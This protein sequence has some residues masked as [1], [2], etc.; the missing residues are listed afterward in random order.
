MFRPL[1]D[2][3]PIRAAASL[4][5]C[6]FVLSITV[7][8]VPAATPNEPLNFVILLADDLG[9][10]DLTSY[11]SDLHATPNID[12]L[13]AESVKFTDAY[14]AAPVCSPTR[15]SI[16]TGKYPARL[17]MT[18]WRESSNNPPLK[19]PVIPPITVGDLPHSQTTIA[20]VLHRAGYLTAHVGKWHLGGASHYPQ[21][22][23]FDANIGGS[24]WG[25]PATFFHPYSGD[26]RYGH[27]FRYVP[28][29]EFGKEGDYLTDQLTDAA[30]DVLDHAGERPFFLNMCWYTVHT[31][32]EARQEAVDR[33]TA[34][35]KPGMNHVNPTYA[36]MVES[37]DQNVGR[38]L[39]KLEDLGVADRTVVI[40]SSDNGGFVNK[41]NGQTV[42][43]NHPLR[44]GKG[45]LYEGG[46][47]VPLLI[48]WP[49]VAP[50]GAV[51]R[52]PV[53]TIDF[54]PTILEMAGLPGDAEHN[55]TVDGKSLAPLLKDPR[56]TLDRKVMCWHYPHYYPT[57]SP[58]SSIRHGNW[59]LLE[60]HEDQ[61]LELYDLE[62][63]LSEEHNLAEKQPSKATELR[64]KLHAWRE[65]VDAQM[66]E[67]NVNRRRSTARPKTAPVSGLITLN[68]EPVAG[69][70]VV[71][72]PRKKNGSAAAGTTDA[73]GMFKMTT[74]QAGDGVIPGGYSVAISKIVTIDEDAKTRQERHLLPPKYAEPSTS[75]L[76]V[77]VAAE[78]RNMFDIELAP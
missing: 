43:N 31:P 54:Y 41:F 12:R 71:F 20:E 74:F 26:Q 39:A 45:S 2:L 63:D 1:S 30:I 10:T 35:L 55:A 51:C 61:H 15:A 3:G 76:T 42:T 59:K 66:P 38:I 37:L 60:Y 9:W 28:H 16:L 50:K 62:N 40:F 75:G 27:E 65:S 46:V 70:S 69:A 24:L 78:G 77:E 73:A 33:Y 58:V 25:A 64:D 36:A 18:I 72:A 11:G 57:T 19:R 44:S 13:A 7:S 22:H 49:G 68:G 6:L 21:T 17:H 53:S 47:R 4:A 14:A 8:E 29:L 32:I 48:R 5:T 67:P 23:G 56:A 52:Q 34:K